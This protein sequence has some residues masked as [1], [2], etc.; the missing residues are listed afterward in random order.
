V[1]G[2]IGLESTPEEYVATMVAVFE[3]V[4]RVLRRDGL[5]WLNLGDC[6]NAA[7]RR[8]H[9]TRLGYAQGT[10]RA[11]T[12]GVDRPR[13]SADNL[14][15][16]DLVGIPWRVALALQANGWF[17]RADCV[18]FKVNGFPESVKDRPTHSHEYVFML[19]KEEAYYYDHVAVREAAVARNWH[20]YTGQ[21]YHAPGQTQQTGSRQKRPP[22]EVGDYTRNLRSVWAVPTQAFDAPHFATMPERIADT[23][24]RAGSRPGDIVFD[25]FGGTGITARVAIRLGRRAVHADLGFHDL[26]RS[27][28]MRNIQLT[29]SL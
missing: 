24:I 19:A 2:Q 1:P 11:S 3:E 4:R 17:L 8:T 10:N 26:A 9:G 15:P 21:S 28:R 14:K 12:A 13:P 29:M 20:N 22:M 25:P 27:T 6:Y 18:W 5:M 7:G 23:C 16:K